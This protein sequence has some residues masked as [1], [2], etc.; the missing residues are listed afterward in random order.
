MLLVQQH[1]LDAVPLR[2]IPEYELT[3]AV[4][5]RIWHQVQLAHEAGIAHRALTADVVLLGGVHSAATGRVPQVSADDIANGDN[6]PI[7]QVWLTSWENGD[8]ASSDLA[9]RMDLVQL[10]ALLALRVGADRAVASAVRILPD[11]E[12]AAIGP[13]LQTVGLPRSTRDEARKHKGIIAEL[14]IALVNRVPAADVEPQPLV[15]F[16]ARRVLMLSLIHI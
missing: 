4:L 15:K 3:D 11:D 7:A 16:G 9:R 13:L 5:D 6:S 10:V 2:D 1:P 14:R 8:V 12:I